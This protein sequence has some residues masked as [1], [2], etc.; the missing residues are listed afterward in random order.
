M[1]ICSLGHAYK[2]LIAVT[3]RA[4]NYETHNLITRAIERIVGRA[5][6]S[7]IPIPGSPWVIIEMKSKGG[8]VTLIEQQLVIHQ[9][10]A[11]KTLILF[12]EV[13][14][15]SSLERVV[16]VKRIRNLSELTEV[17]N[18][19]LLEG[20]T[21]IAQDPPSGTWTPEYP[22][23]VVWRLRVQSVTWQV[24]TSIAL[25]RGYANLVPAPNCDTCHSDDHHRSRCTWGPYL[26]ST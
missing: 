15:H 13:I 23:R 25:T 8:V 22:D 2:V 17:E 12:R 6:R 5:P 3:G 16:E 10:R 18:R 14:K 7:I 9:F 24:P 21:V 19:L 20:A 26:D 1:L 11:R 4:T